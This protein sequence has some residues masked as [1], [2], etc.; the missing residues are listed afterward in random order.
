V[1]SLLWHIEVGSFLATHHSWFLPFLVVL[2]QLATV[3][4]LLATAFSD[5]GIMPR[6]K[7]FTEIYDP[8]TQTYRSRM[9]PRYFD[10]I[11]RGV[12]FKVKYCTTCNI[13]RPPRTTHC[14]V[15]ENCIERFDHHCPWIGNC[16]GKR[17]YWLFYS[18]V[19]SITI[20]TSFVLATSIVEMAYL[21]QKYQDE[22]GLSAG[23]AF[24]KAL[25]DAPL[26]AVIIVYCGVICWFPL[27]LWMYH[28][29]LICTNQ[30]TYEQIKGNYSRS[31]N[32]FNRGP[33]ENCKDVLCSQIRPRFFNAFTMELLWPR[34]SPEEAHTGVKE[35][36]P[37]LKFDSVTLEL[38]PVPASPPLPP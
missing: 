24:V 4:L 16:I 22:S 36:V 27:G 7:D 38:P 14:A 15:C 18:F 6:Q 1:P 30:T 13:Y 34:C 2:I 9:P 37:E 20:L 35:D 31:P 17:N 26:C 11:L 3:K 32:P 28:N 12:P 8:R 23:D 21:C 33:V 29:Y 5:P 25:R 19:T 10:I